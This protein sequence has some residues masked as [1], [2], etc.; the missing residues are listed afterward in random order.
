M[1][2]NQINNLVEILGKFKDLKRSGWLMFNVNLP[3]SDAD[4]SFGVAL[5]T[6]ILA[7]HNLNKQKCMELAL[8]HDLA[9]IYAGDITPHDNISK[10]DKNKLEREGAIRIA[11]ELNWPELIGLAEEYNDKKTPEARFVSLIDKLETLMSAKYYTKNKRS[12]ANF[13]D[14][15]TEYAKTN[16]SKYDDKELLKIKE[17]INTF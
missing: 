3:E 14:E 1:K 12:A 8:I 5:L 17:I 15:F 4:H 9:E 11:K 10:E 7:P 16:A 2:K 6:T 13:L